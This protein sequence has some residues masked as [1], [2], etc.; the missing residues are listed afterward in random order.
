MRAEPLI[1]WTEEPLNA[2]TP[3]SLL[4]R[5]EVT[6]TQLFFVTSDYMLDGRSLGELPLSS[7]VCR[8]LEGEAV[9]G[10]TVAAEGRRIRYLSGRAEV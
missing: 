6:P 2:E 10:T 8:P 9:R 1:V 7:A 3:L 4:C 5:S